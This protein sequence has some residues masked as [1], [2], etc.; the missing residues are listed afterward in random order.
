LIPVS[1]IG[2][3]GREFSSAPAHLDCRREMGFVDPLIY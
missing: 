1:F 2:R 3:S